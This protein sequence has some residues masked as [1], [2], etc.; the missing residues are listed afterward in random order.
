MET[1]GLL[2]VSY[3]CMLEQARVLDWSCVCCRDII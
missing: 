1:L 3:E 2:L